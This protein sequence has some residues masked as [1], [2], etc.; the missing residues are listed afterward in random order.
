M[1]ILRQKEFISKQLAR[2]TWWGHRVRD[3]KGVTAIAGRTVKRLGQQVG[4]SVMHLG[5][6]TK[7]V[8]K[9][10]IDDNVGVFKYIKS[11]GQGLGIGTPENRTLSERLGTLV[12]SA[13]DFTPVTA[14]LS[15]AK[16]EISH[17]AKKTGKDRVRTIAGIMYNPMKNGVGRASEIA[18]TT[19]IAGGPISGLWT[20]GGTNDF[21]LGT[22]PDRIATHIGSSWEKA[23]G[24]QVQNEIDSF[25]NS[26]LGRRM[27][28]RFNRI[29]KKIGLTKAVS[30][31]STLKGR[32]SNSLDKVGTK[33][34]KTGQSISVPV[35]SLFVKRQ[36]PQLIP[37]M[38]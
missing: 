33:L 3:V 23:R 35:K 16:K 2:K 20:A 36:Q 8:G 21:C 34:R 30:T 27:E 25:V 17:A 26:R 38:S 32:A 29:H 31:V 19:G 11:Q 24:N 13:A 15:A 37:V 12:K 10:V 1:I 6:T 22:A 4:D 18:R 7:D 5:R 9:G 28:N 14:H